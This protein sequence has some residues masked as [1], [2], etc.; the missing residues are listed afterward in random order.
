MVRPRAPGRTADF[1]DPRDRGLHFRGR[2]DGD[3][4][5]ASQ[6]VLAMLKHLTS[7]RPVNNADLERYLLLANDIPGVS[8]QAVLRRVSPEPGAVELVA[9][10]A[11]KPFSAQF[12]FDNRGFLRGRSS[13]K[14]CL[15]VNLRTPSPASASRSRGP[16]STPS[17][18]N[19]CSA[20]SMS[21]AFSIPRGSSCVAMPGEA[22]RSRA[23]PPVLVWSTLT[24]RSRAPPST[25]W[26]C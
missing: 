5:A 17:I 20:R 1:C 14:R 26:W 16:S 22:T 11:R 3:I 12:Q 24:Y 8:A 9:K 6:L 10:V 25:T 18:A 19:S 2:A 7:P 15:S 23:A 21:R 13:T 4:G